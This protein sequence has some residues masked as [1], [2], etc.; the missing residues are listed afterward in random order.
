ML[1]WFLATACWWSLTLRVWA[2]EPGQLL[3][4]FEPESAANED[5]EMAAGVLPNWALPTFGGMQFWTDHACLYGYKLQQNALTEHWRVLDNRNIRRCWGAREDCEAELSKLIATAPQ[6]KPPR[7]VVILLH[8]LMRTSRSMSGIGTLIENEDI[9]QTILFEYASTRA[10]LAHHAAA[11]RDVVERLPAD[12]E[13]RFVGHSMGNIVFRHAL[14]DW[15]QNDPAGVIPR[16]KSV[17]MLGPPNQG[18]EIARRLSK[19]GLFEIVTGQGGMELGPA[20]AKVQARLAIP[21]CPCAVVAG[22]IGEIAKQNPLSPSRGDLIVGLEE[23]RL[24]GAEMIVI[25]GAHSFLMDN[26][27]AREA[28]IRFLRAH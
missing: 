28:A 2:Q 27:S 25:S 9:G 20:W 3:D 19:I 10:S 15:T 16:I 13:L 17:V 5:P 23:A 22:D 6:T 1:R 21:Q 11:L 26:A 4:V 24:E 8:G 7:S 18:A 14:G 12:C